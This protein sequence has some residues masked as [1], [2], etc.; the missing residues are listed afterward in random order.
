MLAVA[1]AL[2]ARRL[3]SGV[4]WVDRWAI[5]AA[6]GAAGGALGSFAL[7]LDCPVGGTAHLLLTHAGAVVLA[8]LAGALAARL[9]AR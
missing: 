1:P 8:T 5:G 9:A 7:H 4:V 3:L 6:I 2:F